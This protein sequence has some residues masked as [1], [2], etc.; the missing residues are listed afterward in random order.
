MDDW[1]NVFTRNSFL[2]LLDLTTAELNKRRDT[3]ESNNFFS[4]N[5]AMKCCC[6]HVKCFKSPKEKWEK[7][8]FPQRARLCSWDA[9][10]SCMLSCNLENGKQYE[11]H[12][13]VSVACRPALSILI[14]DIFSCF[15]LQLTLTCCYI[16]TA[17]C[18]QWA[19]NFLQSHKTWG[20]SPSEALKRLLK[21]RAFRAKLHEF[22]RDFFRDSFQ[23]TLLEYWPRQLC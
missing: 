3:T 12:A 14:H 2:L 5:S 10:R 16:C 11:S 17:I 21:L 13:R 9:T 4:L 19:I 23:I 15:A 20:Q 8:F 1:F 22:F 7:L 6:W 18:Y